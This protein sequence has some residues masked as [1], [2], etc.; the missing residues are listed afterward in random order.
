MHDRYG[1]ILPAAGLVTGGVLGMAGSFAPSPELRG[2]AWGIDGIAIIVACAVLV[3]QNVQHGNARLA[4]G[5]L[6]FLLGETVVTSAAAA[7][8]DASGASLAAGTGLWAVGLAL[9]SLA[10]AMPLF[11][12]ATGGIAAVLLG[13]TSLRLFGG[14]NLTPLSQPLPFDAFPFLALTLF[15]W[16]WVAARSPLGSSGERVAEFGD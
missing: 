8:L 1:R 5:F 9:V 10:G 16:A 7:P 11:V 4:T 14:A 13:I 6:V 12:R 15:G 2:L 3:I